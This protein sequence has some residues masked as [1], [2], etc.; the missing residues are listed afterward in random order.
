MQLVKI[1]HSVKTIQFNLVKIEFYAFPSRL[2]KLALKT[3]VQTFFF[4]KGITTFLCLHFHFF[5]TFSSIISIQ[6]VTFKTQFNIFRC[7][8]IFISEVIIETLIIEK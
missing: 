1:I 8:P 5:Q 4:V 6:T 7:K 2:F 3:H